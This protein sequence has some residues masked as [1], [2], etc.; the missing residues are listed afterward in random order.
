MPCVWCG[1]TPRRGPAQDTTPAALDLGLA[2][3]AATPGGLGMGGLFAAVAAPEN[4]RGTPPAARRFEPLAGAVLNAITAAWHAAPTDVLRMRLALRAGVAEASSA[5]L[6]EAAAPATTAARRRTLLGL[7][8]EFGLPEAVPLALGLFQGDSPIEVQAAAL[9]VL[10]QH[11]D[12]RVTATL[13]ESYA[14]TPA[15]LQGR[16]AEVLLSR[17][18]SA[19]AFLERV[20]RHDI[21]VAAVPLERLRPVALHGDVEL[22][23]L[24]RKH[25]GRIEAGT[26]EEKLAEMR[27][28]NNDLRAASGDRARGKELFGKHCATCHKLFGAGGEVGPD[29]TGTA[30]GDTPAL[31]ASIVDPGALVRTPY[32]Q[33]AVATFGGRVVTGLLVAQDGAGVTLLDAQNQR[34]TLT[35]ATIEELR[36]L[37]TSIMPENLLK[38]LS[39]QEVRDLFAYLQGPP[40]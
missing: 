30:R 31:L 26:P 18:A 27:R 37:P 25:W 11:G 21:A 34:T 8:A 6:T 7:F 9:D 17:P 3:R 35:R 14:R 22:D 23:A 10:A 29:L 5:V 2:E 33:Y 13:L 32:L 28:L 15:A 38:L 39:P 24:V 20:D 12:D 40:P 1:D 36:E 4:A 19:R 16:I